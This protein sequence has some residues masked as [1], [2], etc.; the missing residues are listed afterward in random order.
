MSLRQFGQR[1]HRC[2]DSSQG[3]N[4]AFSRYPCNLLRLVVERSGGSQQSVV[5]V[6]FWAF[7]T[8]T[9]LLFIAS[10][11]RTSQRLPCRSE[12]EMRMNDIW[13]FSDY[14]GWGHKGQKWKIIKIFC[15]LYN[16][17]CRA[18]VVSGV[19][20]LEKWW[21]VYFF[22]GRKEQSCACSWMPVMPWS[23][24]YFNIYLHHVFPR[25]CSVPMCDRF[26]PSILEGHVDEWTNEAFVRSAA[27][28]VCNN[29]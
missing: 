13:T 6:Q 16:G 26:L 11:V 4:A 27:V 25:P 21:C 19:C 9:R 2:D 29:Y 7:S 18:W 12:E 15:H 28:A 20:V 23:L 10:G 24:L 14:F 1:T 5:M 22:I 17:A 3:K 8:E